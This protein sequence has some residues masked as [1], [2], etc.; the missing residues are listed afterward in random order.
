MN[1]YVLWKILGPEGK[2]VNGRVILVL[3][4]YNVLTS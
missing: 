4:N 3:F 1:I 2:D